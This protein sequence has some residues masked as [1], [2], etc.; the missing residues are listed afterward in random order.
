MDPGC[1]VDT[2]V[3]LEGIQGARKSTALSIIGGKWFTECDEKMGTKDFYQKIQGHLLVEIAELDSFQRSEVTTIKNVLSQRVDK[4]RPPY[5]KN[6]ETFPRQC[7][8]VGTTNNDEYLRD[9]TGARRFWPV[10]IS[11]IDLP[12]LKADREQLFAEAVHLFKQ[13]TT[14]WEMPK[15]EAEFEQSERAESDV[16]MPTIEN[17]LVGH[18]M[19]NV[20]DILYKALKMDHSKMDR[21]SQA[22]VV[23]I[24]KRL[25]WHKAKRR[26]VSGKLMPNEWTRTKSESTAVSDVLMSAFP[27]TVVEYGT[28]FDL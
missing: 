19:T 7:V 6:L 25:G 14:W 16:W 12:G 9:S 3:I 28:E 17:F 21:N 18:M 10:T 24:L 2:M 5:G 11:E 26:R 8:F 23:S 20:T 15:T 4:F 13:G 22:R 27:T 1:K